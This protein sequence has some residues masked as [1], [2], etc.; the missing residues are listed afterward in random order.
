[1]KEAKAEN[2]NVKCLIFDGRKDRTTVKEKIGKKTH[3]RTVQEEHIS[4]IEEP[5]SR[6]VGH[7]TPKSSSADSIVTQS[8]LL[9]KSIM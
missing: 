8:R 5:N 2:Q 9:W 6:Y 3:R 7:A 1:M 4:L